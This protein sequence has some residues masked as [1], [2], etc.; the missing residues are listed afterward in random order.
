MGCITND[1]AVCA[2]SFS[3]DRQIN[4]PRLYV[5]AAV[6]VSDSLGRLLVIREVEHYR[7]NL[8]N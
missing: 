3:A 1:L 7:C 8:I 2:K 6:N 5:T 4:R